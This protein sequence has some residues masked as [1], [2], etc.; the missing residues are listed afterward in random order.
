MSQVAANM[1]ARQAQP[2]RCSS[3]ARQPSRAAACVNVAHLRAPSTFAG[4]PVR[5]WASPAAQ[6]QLAAS[7]PA[8][9]QQRQRSTRTAAAPAAAASAAAPSLDSLEFYPVLSVQGFISPEVPE[10]T[11][12]TVFALYDEARTLQY[13]GFSKGLRDTLRTLFSRRPEKTHYFKALHLAKLDQQQMLDTRSAWFDGNYGPPPGNKLPHERDQW[14]Q[15]LAAH[16]IS[17][18]GKAAA[19]AELA[20][21]LQ[22]RIRQRG[23]KE[24]FVPNADLLGEGQVDFLPAAALSPEELERQRQLAEAAAKATRTVGFDMDSAPASFDLFY[25]H[26]YQT[27]GG[28]MYD[29]TVTFQDKETQHRVIVGRDYYEPQGVDPQTTVE[30]VFAFLLKKKVPRQTEGMLL[31]SQFSS[32]YFSI[33]QVEQNFPDF[34]A[35]FAELGQLPGEEGFW[36]FNRTQDYGNKGENESPEQLKATFGWS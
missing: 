21:Q 23:C 13:V 15:P 6:Q 31:N 33:S 5:T 29:V 35:E 34:A 25:K 12:A 3:S 10:G 7:A 4:R 20:K 8:R 27:N 19:A 28:W 24:E 9:R 2:L 17:E 16:A 22:Q 26:S 32:N 36:R 11:E 1:V 18:R 30:R 14:Q